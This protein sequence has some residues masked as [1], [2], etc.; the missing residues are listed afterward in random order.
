MGRSIWGTY[1]LGS[2]HGDRP[3]TGRGSDAPPL[4]CDR[5]GV[6]D[7]GVLGL[8]SRPSRLPL[9]EDA[10]ASA[11]ALHPSA[12]SGPCRD[13]HPS[14]GFHGPDER[15]SA[16]P[17]TPRV[18]GHRLLPRLRVSEISRLRVHGKR[19]RQPRPA[20]SQLKRSESSTFLSDSVPRCYFIQILMIFRILRAFIRILRIFRIL[21]AFIRI[22]SELIRILRAFYTTL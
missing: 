18:Y 8:V 5:R 16:R 14:L 21:R 4:W 15:A 1:T 20:E 12:W 13:P 9:W 10:F 2:R 17:V 11:R 22:L 7:V 6:S 19:R 3:G